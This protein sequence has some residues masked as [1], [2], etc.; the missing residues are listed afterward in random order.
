MVPGHRCGPARI[1]SARFERP[2]SA[3]IFVTRFA[4]R[5]FLDR[6]PGVENRHQS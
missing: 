2:D 1:E 6:Q 3:Y 4:E 5:E